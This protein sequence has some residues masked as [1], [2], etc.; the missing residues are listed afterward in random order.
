MEGTKSRPQN[1]PSI[2]IASGWTFRWSGAASI[3]GPHAFHD[4]RRE[5]ERLMNWGHQRSPR[6]LLAAS[7][8]RDLNFTRGYCEKIHLFTRGTHRTG[9]VDAVAVLKPARMPATGRP[10]AV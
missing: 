1:R 9:G 7:T 10:F 4:I 5:V 2:E 6:H 8:G 3:R